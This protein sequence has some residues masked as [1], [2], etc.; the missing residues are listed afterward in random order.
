MLTHLTLP[1]S[2]I[3]VK[4]IDCVE[5]CIISGNIDTK[6]VRMHFTSCCSKIIWTPR[7]IFIRDNP[8]TSY[9]KY[10]EKMSIG[11][12]LVRSRTCVYRVIKN[13]FSGKICVGTIADGW[14]LT[15]HLKV[16]MC[17]IY[18]G[19]KSCSFIKNRVSGGHLFLRTIFW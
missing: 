11:Y 1:L 18:T 9:A 19:C 5:S 16:S 8:L 6:L 4:F 17:G 7:K 15:M 2:F 10:S 3:P 13:S 12:L 14:S